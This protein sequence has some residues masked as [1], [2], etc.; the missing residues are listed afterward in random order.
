MDNYSAG[1]NYRRLL[2]RPRNIV[3]AI[4]LILIIIGGIYF[5]ILVKDN[6]DDIENTNDGAVPIGL[7]DTIDDPYIGGKDAKVIIVEF[8]DF[9]CPYCLSAYYT[10]KDIREKYGDKIKFVYRDMPNDAIHPHARKAAEAGECAQE[11]GKFWELH[12]MI[13]ENQLVDISVPAIKRFASEIGLDTKSFNTCLDSGKYAEE[14]EQDLTTGIIAGVTG[15][16]TFFIN[17]YILTGTNT[18]DRFVNTIDELL[19][20]YEAE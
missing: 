6:V 14:V 19:A 3:I 2:F 4:I 16:P 17:G 8:S 10:L 11:Q 9:Q 7:L 15:T 1:S 12:D 13:F 5:Y 20:I 18:Y